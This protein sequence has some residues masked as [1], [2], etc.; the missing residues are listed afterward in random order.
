MKSLKY[1]YLCFLIS[2]HPA[3]ATT[4]ITTDILVRGG[5]TSNVKHIVDEALESCPSV[6]TVIVASRDGD[7]SRAHMVHPRDHFLEDLLNDAKRTSILD[8]IEYVDSNDPLFILYTSGSTGAPKGL[9]HSTAGYLLYASM[10]HQVRHW[11]PLHHM[12]VLIAIV[13]FPASLRL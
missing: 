12:H 3:K 9:M 8:H 4:V 11:H 13:I 5:K 7:K 6:K 10:T 2:L 1:Q